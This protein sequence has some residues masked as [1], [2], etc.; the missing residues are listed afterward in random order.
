ML[1]ALALYGA[2]ML[3]PAHVSSIQGV[4]PQLR[5]AVASSC[6]AVCLQPY[7]A[8]ARNNCSFQVLEGSMIE[9][10]S[11]ECRRTFMAATAAAWSQT[12]ITAAIS[13]G[14]GAA[15]DGQEQQQQQRYTLLAVGCKAGCVQLWRYKLPQY[16]SSTDAAD[17]PGD[18]ALQ[19][20]GAVGVTAGANVTSLTWTVLPATPPT[21]AAAAGGA[22]S[23]SSCVVPGVVANKLAGDV[24]L[25]AVGKSAAAV[26]CKL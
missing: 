24:L 18:V 20:L 17:A 4:G 12:C 15:A 10:S 8:Y 14:E 26:V 9:T 11:W 19:Y 25:L 3:P 6:L 22:I 7:A 21:T 23:S 2:Y 16:S 13:S 1:E 5:L